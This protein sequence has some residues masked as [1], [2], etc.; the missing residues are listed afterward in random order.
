MLL[1]AAYPYDHPNNPRN[2][3][4]VLPQLAQ[5]QN[6]KGQLQVEI[7]N[8]KDAL[9]KSRI[10]YDAGD[11]SSFESSMHAFVEEIRRL[12]HAMKTARTQMKPPA[13][14]AALRCEQRLRSAQM[15]TSA[16]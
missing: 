7:H 8:V 5:A 3:V 4:A 12:A 6:V 2:L 1:L 11:K 13:K 14:M 10:A 9:E 16:K 15:V